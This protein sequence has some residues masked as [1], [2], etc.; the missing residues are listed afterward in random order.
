M[1]LYLDLIIEVASIGTGVVSAGSNF[2]QGNIGAGFAD[3]GF[4]TVDTALAV[5]PGVPGGIGLARKGAQ[6]GV[7]QTGKKAA[8]KEVE[9][10]VDQ[11]AKKSAQKSQKAVQSA[12]QAQAATNTAEATTAAQAKKLNRTNKAANAAKG[13][14]DSAKLDYTKIPNPK[15]VDA[16]TKPTPRQAREMKKMNEEA[17]GGV[18]RDDVTGEI[19][20]PS[21]KSQKSVTPSANEVQ[22]DHINPV[23][24]GGTRT[25]SNSELRT[26]ANNR[27]KSN[28]VEKVEVKDE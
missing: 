17:N 25:M 21:V 16:S 26:R 15:N 13:A 22:V 3:L 1:G 19:M 14:G 20:V 27:A 11:A 23:S 12:E 8:K 24:N 5:V 28:K 7:K 2:A 9:A 4:A 10:V 6:Q 18:L